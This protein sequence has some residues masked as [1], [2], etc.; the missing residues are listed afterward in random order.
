MFYMFIIWFVCLIT[1]KNYFFDIHTYYKFID[2]ICDIYFC[3]YSGRFSYDGN[4]IEIHTEESSFYALSNGA[5]IFSVI[6]LV[7]EIGYKT[8]RASNKIKWQ[9]RNT[10]TQNYVTVKGL[11]NS[12]LSLGSEIITNLR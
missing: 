10:F 8:Q 1:N 5:F 2:E 4:K 3:A 9:L 11:S 12:I 6:L 7:F